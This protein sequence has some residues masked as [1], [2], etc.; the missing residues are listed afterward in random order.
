MYILFAYLLLQVHGAKPTV[1][2]LC[3]NPHIKAISFVGS[4]QVMRALEQDTCRTF[5]GTGVSILSRY[6]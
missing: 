3:D 1:D 2:F 4:N 6:N 5:L